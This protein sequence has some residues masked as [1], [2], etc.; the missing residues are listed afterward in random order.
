MPPPKLL[1]LI[2]RHGH[3]GAGGG[4]I[5]RSVGGGIGDGVDASRHIASRAFG[6]QGKTPVVGADLGILYAIGILPKVALKF[7]S[8]RNV[9]SPH[10][11]PINGVLGVLLKIRGGFLGQ[12]V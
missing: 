7:L 5:T 3:Y 12:S 9:S 10:K 1:P 4:F 8:L 6:G 2:V 11:I